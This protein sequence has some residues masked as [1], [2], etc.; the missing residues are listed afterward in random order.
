MAA[1]LRPP[2]L[3]NTSSEKWFEKANKLALFT[4]VNAMNKIRLI[5]SAALALGLMSAVPS[6]A[7]A[8]SR[9]DRDWRDRREYRDRDYRDRDY[10]DRDYRDYR[11]D[12]RVYARDFDVDVPLA[13]VP[14]EALR[15]AELEAR[16]RRIES[17][18][19][20]GRDGK[21]FYRF[22]IDDPGRYDR[23]VNI[24][25]QPGGRLLSIEEAEQWDV[26]FV[27]PHRW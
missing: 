10:R 12:R 9:Y 27:H 11:D 16:G 22:R 7:K 3:S 4:K 8:D 15:T 2:A 20:V 14:R 26:R 19:Y 24:R 1:N 13:R 6:F 25:V 17:V 21:L 5:G 18:Q 23:D